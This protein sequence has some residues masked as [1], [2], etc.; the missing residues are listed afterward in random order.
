VMS[1]AFDHHTDC[2]VELF[3]RARADMGLD[4]AL[5]IEALNRWYNFCGRCCRRHKGTTAYDCDDRERLWFCHPQV[6]QKELEVTTLRG[7]MKT[8]SVGLRAQVAEDLNLWLKDLEAKLPKQ[9]REP[10]V[11]SHSNGVGDLPLKELEA[12][13][14]KQAVCTKKDC[15]SRLQPDAK[16]CCQC[17]K[18]V[19]VHCMCGAQ[20]PPGAKFCH[21]CGDSLASR[22]LRSA[23]SIPATSA[24]G[25]SSFSRGVDSDRQGVGLDVSSGQLSDNM[26]A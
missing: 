15:G 11:G 26:L 7:A 4:H 13:V 21:R 10:E 8:L 2:V 6:E 14:L 25:P 16:F 19:Q 20:L 12:K 17:G 22:Q 24:P 18:T 5:R 9:A 3:V 23:E 1:N